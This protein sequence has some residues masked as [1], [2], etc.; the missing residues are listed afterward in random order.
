M[1]VER[2]TTCMKKLAI[3]YTPNFKPITSHGELDFILS[4]LGFCPKP[5]SNA[6]DSAVLWKEYSFSGAGAFLVKSESPPPQPRLPY[7]KIDGLHV[8]TYRSFLESINYYLR[9]HNISDLF[10]IRGMPLHIVHDGNQKWLRMMDDD[11]F[12]VYRDDTLDLSA[13]CKDTDKD[14]KVVMRIASLDDIIVRTL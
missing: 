6:A 3:W 12:F 4:T 1:E 7:P 10:H 11:V 8:N 2:M 5:P 13:T 9:I 14:R